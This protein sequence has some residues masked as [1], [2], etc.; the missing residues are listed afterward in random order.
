M[1]AEAEAAGGEVGDDRLQEFVFVLEAPAVDDEEDVAPLLVGEAAFGAAS[2]V[3]GDGV[4]VVGA[5]VLL[6]AGEDAGDFGDGAADA[7][8]VQTGG[9]GANVRE[10]GDGAERAAAEVE[11]VE[12]DLMGVWV[13][14]KAL[15]RV[16]RRVDLP[17]W[18][19]PTIRRWPVAPEKSWWRRS[20][21]CSKGLST[22]PKGTV[23]WP[24]AR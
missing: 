24:V 17:D 14:A 9:D 5:E 18:G 2:A 15:M 16:R 21:R 6:A 8:G 20:R 22:R 10:G 4:D 13:S 1:D 23:S 12:L 19:P 11:A 3:G 7:F